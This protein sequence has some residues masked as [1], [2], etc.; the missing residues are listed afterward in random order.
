M[1]GEG[2]ANGKNKNLYKIIGKKYLNKNQFPYGK[3]INFN[4]VGK[5][6]L[7]VNMKFYFLVE[8]K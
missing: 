8:K 3:K 2:I 1:L 7:L 4:S 6:T 5:V